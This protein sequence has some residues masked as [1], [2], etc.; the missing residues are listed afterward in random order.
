MVASRIPVSA[1]RGAPYFS[2]RPATPRLTSPSLPTSSPKMH[3]RAGRGQQDV[4]VG[5]QHLKPAH[6]GASGPYSGA[7][8]AT[9]A[10]IPH[11]RCRDARD[12]AFRWRA[13]SVSFHSMIGR[14]TSRSACATGPTQRAHTRTSA[15]AS[16]N[17]RAQR[18]TRRP[19]VCSDRLRAPP[20]QPRRSGPP[21]PAPGGAGWRYTV[22][23]AASR[24][25]SACSLG[26]PLDRRPVRP[27]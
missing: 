25:S 16:A 24:S 7:T 11:S 3:R 10:A 20:T 6:L 23:S 4:K 1:T 19:G 9:A 18:L 14:R 5:L 2:C 12:S 22:P 26:F 27:A 15:C 8:A 17:P 13:C 21:V